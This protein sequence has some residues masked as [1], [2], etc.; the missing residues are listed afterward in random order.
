[1]KTK[2]PMF[3]LE[4]LLSRDQL[5][6]VVGGYGGDGGCS[7]TN[8]CSGQCPCKDSADWCDNG[9]CKARPIT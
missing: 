2:N 7:G 3:N 1:M 6:R 8:E 9:L 4:R 5:R